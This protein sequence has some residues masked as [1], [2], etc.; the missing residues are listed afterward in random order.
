M[1]PPRNPVNVMDSVHALD[2]LKRAYKWIRDAGE[3]DSAF[4]KEMKEQFRRHARA[5]RKVI[6]SE[7]V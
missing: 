3:G 1:K 4:L 7:S 6:G 2:L 5:L